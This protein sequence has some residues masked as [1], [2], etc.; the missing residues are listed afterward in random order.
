MISNTREAPTK[1]I[2]M[3]GTPPDGYDLNDVVGLASTQRPAKVSPS[4]SSPSSRGLR[5]KTK[6]NDDSMD[7]VDLGSV[8]FKAWEAQFSLRLEQM[9]D[10][11]ISA[12]REGLK[13]ETGRVQNDLL[14]QPM[15]SPAIKRL[16]LSMVPDLLHTVV[17][18]AK[19]KQTKEPNYMVAIGSDRPSAVIERGPTDK[20]DEGDLLLEGF[21]DKGQGGVYLGRYH[22]TDSVYDGALLLFVHS[23]DYT[24]K[25]LLAIGVGLSL[26]VQ[27][28]LIVAVIKMSLGQYES[29]GEDVQTEFQRWRANSTGETLTRLCNQSLWSFQGNAFQDLS[30]YWEDG[31]GP[32][33]SAVCVVV[34][35]CQCVVE[36]RNASDQFL[37][38][39]NIPGPVSGAPNDGI[40]LGSDGKLRIVCISNCWRV[41]A[42][43]LIVIPRFVMLI[44]L[45]VFG[46]IF[47]SYTLDVK[48]IIL[49][50]VGLLFIFN[51]DEVVGTVLFTQKLVKIMKSIKP[52]SCGHGIGILSFSLQDLFRYFMSV[53]AI[54]LTFYFCVARFNAQVLEA[55]MTVCPNSEVVYDE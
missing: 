10:N 18:A 45:C 48:E 8:Q 5:G 44:S 3:A 12:L 55:M 20:P 43:V 38:I 25:A 52:L 42:L 23:G 35:V 37:A 49:N 46:G 16:R 28:V 51:V 33:L 17:A 9:L 19:G 30:I 22:F 36:Y 7:S 32:M 41:I 21:C 11:K 50:A 27:A 40:K 34:W 53:V 14:T 47:L 54:V 24:D 26:L 2:R 39:L 6:K 29:L 31:T 15:V 1:Q 4:K 13:S